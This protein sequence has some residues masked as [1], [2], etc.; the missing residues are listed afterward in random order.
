MNKIFVRI[1]N[2]ISID[3]K[4]INLNFEY[5]RKSQINS[6]SNNYQKTNEETIIMDPED[7][8]A[9]IKICFNNSVI[10][11]N[12]INNEDDHIKIFIELNQTKLLN[13][14]NNSFYFCILNFND[15]IDKTSFSFKIGKLFNISLDSI[16]YNYSNKIKENEIKNEISFDENNISIDENF[17]DYE[18]ENFGNKNDRMREMDKINYLVNRIKNVN[19]LLKLK[20]FANDVLLKKGSRESIY[21]KSKILENEKINEEEDDNEIIFDKKDIIIINNDKEKKSE[22]FKKSISKNINE[23]NELNNINNIEKNLDKA[24]SKTSYNILRDYNKTKS[25][26]FLERKTVLFDIKE[27]DD[28]NIILDSIKYETFLKEQN[29]LNTA[30]KNMEIRETFCSGFFITSFPF[31]NASLIE[32]TEYL[33]ASCSHKQCSIL[34]SLKPE[35]LMRYP[36]KDTDEIEINNLTATICFPGGIKICHSELEPEKMKDYLT[37]LTNQKGERLYIM[38]Y[39]FYL[40]MDKEEFDK[41]IT[42]YPL[43]LK[44]NEL[45]EK[46]K[47]ID[48][49][50]INDSTYQIFEELKICKELDFKNSVYIPYCLALISR[51]PYENQIKQCI[52]CIFKIIEYQIKDKN[53]KINELLMYLI[54]SIPIPNTNSI[55]KF[56]LPYFT[57]IENNKN[58]NIITL[59]PPSFKD[60]NILNSNIIELLKIFRI[61]NII[62]IIRLLLFEKKIVFIDSDYSRLSNVINSFL[63]LLYPFQ[64]VHICIPIISIQMMKYLETF[65][66]FLAGVHPSFIPYIKKYLSVNS[67]DKEQVYLI[68]IEEDKIRISDFL[69]GKK[70][71]K[72]KFLHENLVNLPPWMYILLNH[73]LT[74]IKSKM[75]NLKKEEESQFNFEIQNAFIELFVEMF[76]DYNDFIYKVGDEAIFNKDSFLSKKNF[77]EKKFY[78]EF[79]D[80]QMFLQFKQDI[81]E[82]GFDYF[83]MKVNERNNDKEKLEKTTLEKTRTSI[84]EIDEEKRKNNY[85]INHQFKNIIKENEKKINKEDNYII[86]YLNN[87]QDGDYDNSKCMI[88]L[89]PIYQTIGTM[90]K[91]CEYIKK[92][93]S[94]KKGTKKTDEDKKREFHIY[95]I[96]EQIKEYILKIFKT[97]IDTNQND[98]KNIIQ[99][100]T[101][102]EKGREYFI[103]IISKN[104]STIV[105]LPNNSFTILYNLFHGVL[106]VLI[107]QIEKNENLL[108]D[109]VLL[110]KSTMNYGKKEKKKIITIWDMLKKKLN[111]IT[112]IYQEKFW[113]EWYIFEINNNMNL[114]GFLL[115][116]VKNNIL[117]SIAKTMKDLGIDKSIIVLYTDNLMKMKF[118]S[119]IDLITKTKKDISDAL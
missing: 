70:I 8:N 60:I 61:K 42:Q 55:V 63:I 90:D 44:L 31:Q 103:K 56:N 75:K 39:H 10:S 26:S 101:Y 21:E 110:L 52:D 77:L 51:Y 73:L 22:D 54:H 34:K 24:R 58:N 104:L 92:K 48:L 67:D 80:T 83:K 109:A 29:D 89:M 25:Q 37:L 7:K 66:P 112:L 76:A 96:E 105:I 15:I 13:K 6:N 93:P 74:N 108:K 119:N 38:T 11:F 71:H 98:F 57:Y 81:L 5:I 69:K 117:I 62:R 53:L 19:K 50:N 49:K 59:E 102:E 116:E 78:K 107:V 91:D 68:F 28:N 118:E 4:K 99:I 41:K 3:N 85:I 72:T 20:I 111:V 87:I 95:K 16:L 17:D 30:N 2:I 32:K 84:I 114:N 45:E 79:L 100:L 35:I 82:E 47:T 88:Y 33:P 36:L 18:G 40:K 9:F 1:I 46:I 94:V 65:L 12:N 27:K 86:T 97:D 14:S 113:N 115:N 64:W 43:K 106:L 23:N